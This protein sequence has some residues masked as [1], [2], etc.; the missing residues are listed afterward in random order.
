MPE[1]N[2]N[3]MTT[4]QLMKEWKSG[5]FRAPTNESSLGHS[6]I[7]L[8]YTSARCFQAPEQT[9]LLARRL[10]IHIDTADLMSAIVS[11]E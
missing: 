8:L 6:L 11:C 3:E 10:F 9:F 2:Y 5:G 7:E 4:N 1:P